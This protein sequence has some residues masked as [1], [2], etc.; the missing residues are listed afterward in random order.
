MNSKRLTV[1]ASLVLVLSACGGNNQTSS[2]NHYPTNG[3]K[4][5]DSEVST[6]GDPH[7]KVDATRVVL[8][9]EMSKAI[10]IEYETRA[11]N[12]STAEDVFQEG[13]RTS[14]ETY[15]MKK[16]RT[17]SIELFSTESQKIVGTIDP[18]AGASKKIIL[19]MEGYSQTLNCH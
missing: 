17:R 6:P 19:K 11:M 8:D 4:T 2:L 1:S 10:V 3:F 7:A 16:T 12:V 15:Q 9:K 5:C 13:F 14:L 18:V